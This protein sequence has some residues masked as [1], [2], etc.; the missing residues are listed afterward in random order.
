MTKK[1]DAP[2]DYRSE[3]ERVRHRSDGPPPQREHTR[4]GRT[5]QK[6]ADQNI[7][8]SGV[9][10]TTHAHGLESSP[11]QLLRQGVLD[12]LS[13]EPELHTGDLTVDVQNGV[14]FLTGTVDTINTKYHA[15]HTAKRVHGVESVENRLKI[16]VGN[17][18]DEFTRGSSG[19]RRLH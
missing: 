13:S 16:R 12:L 1:G 11:D 8:A 3:S 4:G 7:E 9:A 17:A 10:K 14:V 6:V 19:I 15:E 18:L 5:P 2:N